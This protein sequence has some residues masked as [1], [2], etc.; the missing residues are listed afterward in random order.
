M[1]SSAVSLQP[2]FYLSLLCL[3]V[4]GSSRCSCHSSKFFQQKLNR[5]T[6]AV[7]LWIAKTP[8]IQE[9]WSMSR[10]VTSTTVY[11]LSSHL[12][13][14]TNDRGANGERFL[15]ASWLIWG[16]SFTQ[17]PSHGQLT[18]LLEVE[19]VVEY[20]TS[21]SGRYKDVVTIEIQ[22]IFYL[23]QIDHLNE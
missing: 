8:P 6:F 15:R 16:L 21:N 13:Q 18:F 19:I 12:A 10:E 11:W 20:N 23:A 3:Q 2:S 22:V 1:T 5:C 17:G 4:H 9:E 14:T 7:P